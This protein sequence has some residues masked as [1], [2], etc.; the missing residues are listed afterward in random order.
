MWDLILKVPQKQHEYDE[1]SEMN[2]WGKWGG[3]R[4]LCTDIKPT[5]LIQTF[6]NELHL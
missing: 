3:N 6:A 5:V 4:G 1:Y 2:G